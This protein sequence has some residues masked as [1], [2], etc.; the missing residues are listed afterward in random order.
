MLGKDFV[1]KIS[2]IENNGHIG[3]RYAALILFLK[4]NETSF[5]I[6]NILI[7]FMK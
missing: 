6:I 5:K 1:I 4:I 3:C 2:H 7:Y